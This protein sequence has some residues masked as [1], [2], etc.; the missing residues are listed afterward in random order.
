M[1]L[2]PNKGKNLIM[3]V[4]GQKFE[5]WPV[6][7]KLI[8]TDDKN[9]VPI[10]K[11]YVSPHLQPGDMLFISEKAVAV[12]QGR[13]YHI[14]SVKP[15]RLA[16]ILSGF[17]T[18][19]PAGIGLGSPQTM[20]LAIEEVGVARILIAAALGAAA[21]LVGIRGVFYMIAGHKAR[22]IDGAVSYAIPP[23]NEYI[24]KGPSNAE[25]VAQKISAALSVP[26]AIV[27]ANDL[28][29]NILGAS[30]GVDCKLM[31]KIIKDNPLGQTDECTPVGIIRPVHG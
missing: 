21:K 31:V 30:A 25:Q 18:K 19:T 15:S 23:Y 16:T 28:G 22:S 2:Q 8:T 3:E 10:I 27:D 6:K 26:A 24:S 5:R 17:V 7:T 20:E 14:H 1:E 11:E 13:S 9:I 12:T 4:N 29:V